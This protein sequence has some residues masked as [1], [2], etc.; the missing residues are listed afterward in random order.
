MNFKKYFLLQE[1]VTTQP[2]YD[3]YAL[4]YLNFLMNPTSKWDKRRFSEF[5]P[6]L[7][8]QIAARLAEV[9]KGLWEDFCADGISACISEGKNAKDHM[10][11]VPYYKS[12]PRKV[13]PPILTPDELIRAGEEASRLKKWKN[14]FSDRCVKYTYE[15]VS[16]LRPGTDL[17]LEDVE[18]LVKRYFSNSNIL[19]L[20]DDLIYL[21]GGLGFKW[22]EDYGKAAWKKITKLMKDFYS[23][24]GNISTEQLDIL[25]DQ[26]HHTGCWLNKFPN[27]WELMRALEQKKD[28]SYPSDYAEYCSTEVR[29]W[30]KYFAARGYIPGQD[31]DMSWVYPLNPPRSKKM[32]GKKQTLP[33]LRPE[34]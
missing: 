16:S 5:D 29:R 26:V 30:I 28:A 4:S 25:V 15:Y 21:F 32:A 14:E 33:P 27:Y 3:F 11:V 6:N 31:E 34:K 20:L 8:D 22:E 13:G 24:R 19:D 23:T 9:R 12:K 1:S 18:L 10:E 17:K 7:K 2:L